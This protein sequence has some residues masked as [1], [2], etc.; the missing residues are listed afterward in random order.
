[1]A[2]IMKRISFIIAALAAVVFASCNKQE[3]E[4]ITSFYK[5]Y[6]SA[7]TEVNLGEGATATLTFYAK[8]S[9]AGVD[10]PL[11]V[12]FQA[13]PSLVGTYNAKNGTDYP[14]LPESCYTVQTEAT[15]R[16]MYRMSSEAKAIVSFNQDLKPLTNYVLPIVLTS[17]SGHSKA[18]LAE[19]N[20]PIF[21]VVK[22]GKFG[23]G[24]GTKE[25]PY[26]IYDAQDL[27]DIP[28]KAPVR[29]FGS[30]DAYLAAV[31]TYF[32]LANDI[33]LGGVDWTPIDLGM[34]KEEGKK[35]DFD[36]D[37]KTIKG[38]NVTGGEQVGFFKGLVGDIHDLNIEGNV[39]TTAKKAGILVGQAS[40]GDYIFTNIYRC[41]AKGTV[42]CETSS[43]SKAE[44][45]LGGLVGQQCFGDIYECEADVNIELGGTNNGRYVGGIVGS[46]GK[47]GL[48]VANCI[49]KGTFVGKEATAYMFGGILGCAQNEQ[50][51]ILNCISLA[52]ITCSDMAGGII[53]ELNHN[54][55]GGSDRTDIQ[56]KTS[57]VIGCIAWNDA[58]N[59]AGT[60]YGSGAIIGLGGAGEFKD[61]YRKADLA[62]SDSANTTAG[63]ATTVTS[64]TGKAAAADAT[65]SKV[66]KDLKWDETIWDLSGSVPAL[67]NI[68]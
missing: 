37:G 22:V 30:R 63:A 10:G 44:V 5:A 17:V 35:I 58:I 45:S 42:K 7:A 60:K 43:D 18:F 56:D 34:A 50:N 14:A 49:S 47:K 24:A 41:S 28:T 23:G 9:D 21:L 68:K 38:F 8:T 66:A 55:D 2:K 36:G 4:D 3:V 13:D 52:T 15:V 16:A 48:I 25:S 27:K 12:T 51:Q 64:Y 31:P 62:F 54:S 19:N 1:M 65:A 11:S 57:K 59:A 33:D 26:M 39:T 67:K 53:G 61:C 29:Q 20:E 32:K 6:A 40:T 46:F